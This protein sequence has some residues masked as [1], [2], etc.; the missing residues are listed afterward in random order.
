M[1]NHRVIAF[2]T[3]D[4]ESAPDIQA[5]DAANVDGLG[6]EY[7]DSGLDVHLKDAQRRGE[8]IWVPIAGPGELETVQHYFSPKVRW[9]SRGEMLKNQ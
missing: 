4:L 9:V 5:L 2:P 7:R 3:T 6:R 8:E 1:S